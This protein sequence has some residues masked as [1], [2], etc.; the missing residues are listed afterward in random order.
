L[1]MVHQFLLLH[2]F[3]LESHWEKR[4][5][6]NIKRVF[7][8]EWATQYLWAKP[9]VDFVGKIH[10]VNWCMYMNLLGVVLSHYWHQ[11]KESHLDFF[12][13]RNKNNL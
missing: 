13:I 3:L 2:F 7:K 1:P 8:D 5:K 4:K 12:Q 6:E 9:M 11:T 10:M